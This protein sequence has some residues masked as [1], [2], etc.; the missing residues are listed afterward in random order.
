MLCSPVCLQVGL[1]V[2]SRNCQQPILGMGSYN[3][4]S[5]PWPDLNHISTTYI[6]SCK[7]MV[8]AEPCHGVLCTPPASA[9]PLGLFL[10]V[11]KP[12][13]W[14]D[15]C[16]PHQWLLANRTLRT[17]SL[18]AVTRSN[19]ALASSAK[20]V[21]DAATASKSEGRISRMLC[22]VRAATSTGGTCKPQAGN[23]EDGWMRAT[24]SERAEGR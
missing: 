12:L 22:G 1:P 15:P 2:P 16:L 4:I 11:W 13:G 24:E 14:R 18:P 8:T 23:W 9:Q 21:G 20:A 6:L 10:V 7:R 17:L 19:V 3:Q 5:Q